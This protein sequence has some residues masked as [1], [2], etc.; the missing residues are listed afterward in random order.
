[1]TL[2]ATV[3]LLFVS[4]IIGLGLSFYYLAKDRGEGNKLENFI[5]WGLI[6]STIF[7]ILLF[8]GISLGWFAP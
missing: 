4:I 1:M 2:E 6:I 5:A 8:M 7:A 3:L